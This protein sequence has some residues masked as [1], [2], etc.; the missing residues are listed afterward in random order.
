MI[1]PLD[2]VWGVSTTQDRV[3]AQVSG[4]PPSKA[5]KRLFVVFQAAID[6]SF[7]EKGVFVLGGCIATAEAW[8]RD[9]AKGLSGGE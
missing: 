6:E 1:G 2:H 8:I 3:W 9:A 7:E 4:L 5:G